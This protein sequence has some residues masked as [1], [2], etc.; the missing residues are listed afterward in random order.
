MKSWRVGVGHF[1]SNPHIRYQVNKVLDSGRLSYGPNCRELEKV[2]AEMHGCKYGVL[3][4]SGTSSLHVAL[5]AAKTRENWHLMCE[6]MIPSLTFVAT[7]NIVHHNFLRPQLID[8]DPDTYNMSLDS[9]KG[10]LDYYEGLPPYDQNLKAIIPVHL[11]GQPADV[12]GIKELIPDD[13]VVIEDSCECVGATHHGEPVGSLGD[14]GCFSFYVAHI[15]TGGVGG[16]AITNDEELAMIM[17]SLVN[18]GRDVTAGGDMDIASSDRVRKARFQFDR[19]GHSFR[20]TELEAGIILGQM[21]LL[22]SNIARRQEV[23]AMYSDG[24]KEFEELKLPTIAEGNTH[25]FMMY[26]II[27]SGDKW[28]LCTWLEENGIETREMLPLTNQ[29]AYLIQEE[30]YPAAKHVN[31]HGFYIGCHEG[32]T[33]DDVKF[34]VEL[35]DQFFSGGAA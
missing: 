7:K 34:I 4:N 9:L 1:K 16:M 3:S 10:Q 8:I 27:Y 25:S 31:D 12:R 14:V 18:H 35:F 30:N 13:V 22:E 28:R 29:P 32:V 15:L 20:I 11:F 21:H 23:A 17:R 6:V 33:D 24:L 2:F 26:P 5:Q 19:I